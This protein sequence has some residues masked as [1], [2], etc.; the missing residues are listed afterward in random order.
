MM[1][2]KFSGRC[3]CGRPFAAGD[4]ITWSRDTG[5]RHPGCA[6]APPPLEL[7]MGRS[8]ARTWARAQRDSDRCHTDGNCSSVC[9]PQTCPCGD[10]GGWFRCC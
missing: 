1:K 10:G 2:A 4:E 7:R 3:G 6:G 8:R 5:A 9:S